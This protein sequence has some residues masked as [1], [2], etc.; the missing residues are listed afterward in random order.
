MG[1]SL[2]AM[3]KNCGTY[4]QSGTFFYQRLW[5]QRLSQIG[6]RVISVQKQTYHQLW[7]IRLY[8]TLTA[9]AYLLLTRPVPKQHFTTKDLLLK[10]IEL[11]IQRIA[12]ELGEPIPRDCLRVDRKGAYLRAVFI[13]RLGKPGRWVKPEKKAEAFSVLIQPW[14]RRNR[15]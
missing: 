9:Q 5:E 8:G 13:W 1:K 15:N 7:D 2:A 6:F 3:L 11:E 10:Q 12:R 4:Y 14:L